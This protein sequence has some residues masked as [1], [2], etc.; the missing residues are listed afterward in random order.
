MRSSMKKNFWF[1]ISRKTSSSN[2]KVIR[3]FINLFIN[4]FINV[5]H[6]KIVKQQHAFVFVFERDCNLNSL[7]VR[8]ENDNNSTWKNVSN[9]EIENDNS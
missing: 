3:I 4:L 9:K 7:N 5:K 8:V 6:S 2:D 1:K